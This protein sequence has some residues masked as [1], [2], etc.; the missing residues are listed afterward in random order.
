[1]KSRSVSVAAVLLATTTI[2]TSAFAESL[3]RVATV[4]LKAEITGMYEV[5]PDLFFNTQHPLKDLT[6]AYAKAS[7]GVISNVNWAAGE[8]AARR[9]AVDRHQRGIARPGGGPG[10]GNDLVGPVEQA[11]PVVHVPVADFPRFLED[12]FG[13][14]RPGGR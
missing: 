9:I 8:Q 1:M 11:E 10:V 14:R 7:V 5:G 3:T 13:E 4:P 2:A 6:N 12:Q